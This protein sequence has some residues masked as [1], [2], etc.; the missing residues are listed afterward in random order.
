M[1]F[2]GPALCAQIIADIATHIDIPPTMARTSF[3][4]RIFLIFF[5]PQKYA[6]AK[7][8]GENK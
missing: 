1:E 4:F 7:R 8:V 3:P 5:G 6:T 2:L